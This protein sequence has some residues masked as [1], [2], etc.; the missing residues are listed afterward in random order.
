MGSVGLWVYEQFLF[1]VLACPCRPSAL[2]KTT[3]RLR[4]S[5]PEHAAGVKGSH[6]PH[7][8]LQSYVWQFIRFN[9]SEI[10]QIND[11]AVPSRLKIDDQIVDIG[12]MICWR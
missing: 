8:A 6:H 12:N 9:L 11:Q 7:V 2:L 1:L 10:N 3:F 5:D 4:Y